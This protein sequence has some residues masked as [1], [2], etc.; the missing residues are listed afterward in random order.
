MSSS[1][2]VWCQA[3]IAVAFAASAATKVTGAAAYTAFRRWLTAGP[4]VPARLARP[5]APVMIVAEAATAVAAAVPA[6]ATGGFAAAAVL[7]AV[8]S[9]GI[10][11]MMRRRVTVPCRCFGAGR[12]AP[13]ALHLIRNGALWL[14]A[15]TG[16]GHA[17]AGTS[18][19]PFGTGQ[20]VA[21]L[22]GAATALLLIN[23][24]EIVAVARPMP[25]PGRG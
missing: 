1:L 9:A 11:S 22:A 12:G 5:L 8:F 16:G 25:G 23:L 19:T 24:E 21:A 17:F 3:V 18:P 4:G 20:A 13:G 6:S 2:M 15:I 14:I 10:R 7:L